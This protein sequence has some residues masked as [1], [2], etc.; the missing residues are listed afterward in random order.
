MNTI[1]KAL[2][3]A[4]QYIADR[5]DEDSEDDDIDLLDEVAALIQEVTE[6]E[7]AALIAAANELELPDW[8]M[9]IG[10]VEEK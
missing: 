5:D 7:R 2:V 6:P 9:Q 3:I 10:L 4:V 8:P 1:A